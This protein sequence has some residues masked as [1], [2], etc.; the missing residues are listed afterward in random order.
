MVESGEGFYVPE[1]NGAACLSCGLC[2]SVCPQLNPVAGAPAPLKVLAGWSNDLQSRRS[3]SSGAAFYEIAADFIGKGGVVF[4]VVNDNGLIEHRSARTLEEL[5]GMRGSKYVQ[6]R[7]GSSYREADDCLKRGMRV[8]FSGTPCQIAGLKSYLGGRD[9]A[10]LH[11][12]DLVCHGV[13][14]MRLFN[15]YVTELSKRYPGVSANDYL[16]RKTDGWSINPMLLR[17]GSYLNMEGRDAAFMELYLN[18]AIYNEVCYNCHY[19]NVSRPGDL[20]L[21]D[22]WGIGR[23]VPFDGDIS[24]GC[25][26]ILV[27]TEKG[28]KMLD[29]AGDRLCTVPRPLDEAVAVNENLRKCSSRPSWRDNVFSEMEKSGIGTVYWRRIGRARVLPEAY[30]KMHHMFHLLKMKICRK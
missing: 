11:T 19:A 8:L 14:P 26:L 21:G 23:T 1:V 24:G 2:V 15:A 13:P 6:S 28:E 4:G 25:S 12:I 30:R 18:G 17:G 3:S 7:I 22:F 16:F 20:T 9:S 5:K 10:N 27:N 29:E